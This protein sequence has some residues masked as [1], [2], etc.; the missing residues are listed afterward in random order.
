MARRR[1]RDLTVGVVF[2][3]ALVILGVTIMTIGGESRLFARKSYYLI[4]FPQADGLVIGSPVRMAGV[5]VGTVSNIR[6]STDPAEMGIEVEVGV[7]RAYAAR[8]RED[9][10]AALRILQL[11]TGE[12]FVEIIP[13]T[14]DS[15]VLAEGS[16]IQLQQDPELLEQAA[17]AAEN[18]NDI[19]VSLKNI[20]ATLEAGEGLIGQM[21][22]DPE[23]GQEGLEALRGAID[24]L[25]AL[26]GDLLAGRGFVGRLLYD[27]GFAA[28]VDDLSRM[29]EG[30]SDIVGAI[31]PEQGAVGALVQEGAAGQQAIEDLRDAAAS[32]KNVAQRMEAGEGLLGELL[33][34]SEYDGDMAEDLG[35]I[36]ANLRE[37]TDKINRGEGTLGQLV[38]EKRLHDGMEQV[39]AGV[40]DSKFARWLLR[41][42]RKK[43][44]KAAEDEA[45]AP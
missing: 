2:A 16:Q 27:Q 7:D 43:G 1:A 29:I 44:I 31:S 15:T 35:M 38:N 26:T 13:G 40:N 11:L 25:R 8:V 24:N 34:S 21:I 30:L 36:L 41:R 19:T 23:F 9:S 18:I 6:L 33:Q 45:E 22:N 12:K 39:V 20:L 4:V 5:Q 3:L 17:M 32:L 42:Y 28:R 10:A 14:L 37:I